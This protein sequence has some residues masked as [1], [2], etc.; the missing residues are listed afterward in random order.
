MISLGWERAQSKL[1]KSKLLVSWLR[2]NIGDKT[3]DDDIAFWEFLLLGTC[4]E[5]EGKI[6]LNCYVIALIFSVEQKDEV[7]IYKTS[8][9]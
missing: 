9:G 3:R 4:K 8:K 5:L 7:Q 2:Q 6:K 1:S